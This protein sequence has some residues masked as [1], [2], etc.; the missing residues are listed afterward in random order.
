MSKLNSYG[1]ANE[2]LMESWD[3]DEFKLHL[4]HE[5]IG[6]DNDETIDDCLGMF[7]SVQQLRKQCYNK[8]DTIQEKLYVLNELMDGHGIEPIQVSEELYQ[9]AYYGNCIGEY[10]NLGDTY[11]LTI[12]YNTMDQ[13]FEFNSWGEYFEYHEQGLEEQLYDLNLM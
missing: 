12:I 8:P 9:D 4:I 1:I 11:N 6:L 13:K 2:I 3:I 10:I 5:V 7:K